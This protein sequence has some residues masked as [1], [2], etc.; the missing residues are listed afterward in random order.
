M[1]DFTARDR[2]I[3]KIDQIGTA[4]VERNGSIS[5]FAKTARTTELHQ[6]KTTAT[7]MPRKT[8]GVKQLRDEE[9]PARRI[10]AVKYILLSG[11]SAQPLR[12]WPNCDRFQV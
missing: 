6:A 5:I 8:L 10:G 9:T 1:V 2:G 7:K 4:V 12:F 3:R 11:I